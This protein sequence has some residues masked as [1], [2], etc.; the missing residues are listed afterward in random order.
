MTQRSGLGWN[1]LAGAAI[2]T[3]ADMAAALG[4]LLA[5][6]DG[7]L[8]PG[9][10]RI[11]LSA[12]GASFDR[13]AIELEGFARRLWGAVPAAMG[14]LDVLDWARLR[15]GLAH[16][17][18][19]DH[20][21]FW[22]WPG[23]QDQRLVEMAAIGFALLAVPDRAWQPMT[24]AA[25][26]NVAT[27]LH[28]AAAQVHSPNNWMFFR[29]LVEAGLRR[30]GEPVPP[31]AGDAYRAEIEALYL[32]DGWY[33]DG[34]GRR[35]DH[36][37]GFAFHTYAL[38]LHKLAP[39][40]DAGDHLARA[41]LFAPQFAAWFDEDGRGLAYGRS[42]TYRFA[43]AAFFGA[44]ALAE[45]EDPVL[46]W[47]VIKGLVLRHLRHWRDQP[48][49][50]RDGILSV[51]YAY[52]N[53]LM[54]EAYN[55][56]CSPLWALKAFFPLAL[57]ADHPFWTA[58]ELP[59]PTSLP[60]QQ[61]APGFLMQRLPDQTVALAAGQEARVFRH[62]AEKYAK[63]A[64]SSRFPFGVEARDATLYTAS[65]DS[66]LGL[67]GDGRP[68]SVRHGCKSAQISDGAVHAVWHAYPDV[69][70]ETWLVPW[71]G[72]HLRRHTIT[73]PIALETIEGGFAIPRPDGKADLETVSPGSALV[74]SP[75]ASR[76]VDLRS[77]RT[78]RIHGPDPNGN[79]G[80]ARVWV[81]QLMQQIKAGDTVLDCWCAAGTAAL[82]FDPEA[83]RRHLDK[84]TA[85]KRDWKTV[86]A[87][88]GTPGL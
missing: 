70:I 48:M 69:R 38:L 49:A 45:T 43:M 27:Y 41:R 82:V 64:Y 18:D 65:L 31:G 19:P 55:S 71:L 78:A 13:A 79:L 68:W 36:Y 46:P 62:G 17:C 32:G 3:R 50:D 37:T 28:H 25:K 1:P 7:Y 30:V 83:A 51:G 12:A 11:D 40:T 14:G 6:L 16:G 33:R 21:E 15:E 9:G 29:L 80:H 81:P 59:L 23:V 63:F 56:A 42:M 2:Q 54:A 26:R 4:R 73:S 85:E 20:P 5:P 86:L 44:Y 39:E 87:M 72:G 34:P 84:V 57:P 77:G 66:A 67:Q 58:E 24:T 60:T 47:G 53:P 88:T 75:V 22:G 74:C 35:V 61:A 76:I 10:A 52:P 8:S